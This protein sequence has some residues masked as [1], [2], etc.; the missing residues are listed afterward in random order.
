MG[1][2]F[3]KNLF[4]SQLFGISRFM[5]MIFVQIYGYTLEK[6]LR[7]YACYFYDLNG[8]TLYLGNSSYPPSPGFGTNES[9][10]VKKKSYQI[11]FARTTKTLLLLSF[12]EQ[13]VAPYIVL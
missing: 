3:C 13:V 8:T 4:I 5:G 2:V 11:C 7:I 10:L 6:F 12:S 1:I 9:L